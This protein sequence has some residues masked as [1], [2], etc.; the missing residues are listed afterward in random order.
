VVVVLAGGLD[1]ERQPCLDREPL[2][3]VRQEG[4]R[5]LA[6]AVAAEGERYLGVRTADEVDGGRGSGFVHRHGRGAVAG[7]ARSAVERVGNPVPERGEDVLDGVVLVDVEVAAGE[8]F[9][10]E[11]AVK[12]KQGEQV[13]EE[14]DAGGDPGAALPVEVE[15]DAERGLRGGA[16]DDRGSGGARFGGGAERS[17]DQ[18]VLGGEP[19]G[20]PERI[21]PAADD[22]PS[23]LQL[24]GAVGAADDD[25]VARRRRAVEP[26]R[27]QRGAHPSALGDRLLHVEP[28]VP[29]RGRGDPGRGRGDGRR[30]AASVE[31]ARDLRRGDRVADAQRREP[32][33]LRQRPQRDEVRRLPDQGRDGLPAVFEVR[34]VDDDGGVRQ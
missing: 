22:E 21:R 16:E 8:Q 10:V 27:D 19:D 1:V 7:D 9:E 4:D 3:R 11:A 5:E 33:R 26:S 6:D 32:E 14:A 29:E 23:R 34:L 2:E 12:R 17:Q 31:L 20:D 25:E 18:I 24:V 13:V 28:R 15:R 30:I